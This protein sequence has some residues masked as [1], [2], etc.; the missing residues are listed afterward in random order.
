MDRSELERWLERLHDQSWGWALACCGRDRELAEEALQSAYLR[1]LSGKAR[2]DDR[3]AI[4]TWVFGVIRRTALEE[5]RRRRM[6]QARE[7]SDEDATGRAVDPAVGAEV[8]AERSEL[9]ESLVAALSTI[10]TRQREVLELV[11]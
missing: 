6:R 7:P 2:F 8:A 4:R 5:N 1:I 3:S 10:S 9:R 11:F